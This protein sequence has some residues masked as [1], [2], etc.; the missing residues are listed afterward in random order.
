MKD[1]R[2]VMDEEFKGKE[3]ENRSVNDERRK[4]REDR[5]GREEKVDAIKME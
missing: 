1:G 3:R 2:R 5:K 4:I